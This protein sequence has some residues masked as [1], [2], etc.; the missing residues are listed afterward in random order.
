[1]SEAERVTTEAPPELPP[2]SP[3]RRATTHRLSLGH[4]LHQSLRMTARDW[5]AGELT[6]L[7]LALVLAVAALSSVGFLADRLHQGL[8]RDARRMIAADFIVRSDHPVDSQFADKAK[9]LGLDT[10]TT[11]IFPSMVNSTASTPV[12]RLAAVKA[13][14]AGYPLRGELKIALTAGGPDRE[15]RGIPPP[16]EVWVDQQMLDAL[17]ARIGDKVKVGGRDFTIG[18]LITRELDRGFAFVNFSPRLM[19]RADDLASTGLTGY[20]SRVTYRLLVAGGDEPVASS[21]MPAP[22]CNNR[23]GRHRPASSQH[24]P[25]RDA[26]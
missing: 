18:A 9:A 13:V 3:K 20:G 8:E 14:S 5:R 2:E 25:Q 17:K 26:G 16:G 21:L 10:A 4:L 24:P 15:V 19:M 1:L 6:M 12:S 7:L 11:A 23:R 22:P